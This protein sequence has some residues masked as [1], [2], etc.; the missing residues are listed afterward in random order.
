MGNNEPDYKDNLAFEPEMTMQNVF[1]FAV[2]NDWVED[3]G[4]AY[5]NISKDDFVFYFI[6][7]K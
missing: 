3:I 7:Y 5:H 1:K 6:R 4:I 2:D